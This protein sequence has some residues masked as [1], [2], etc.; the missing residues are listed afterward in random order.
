[1]QPSRCAKPLIVSAGGPSWVEARIYEERVLLF[2]ED[3]GAM[4][5]MACALPVDRC[6]G[7]RHHRILGALGHA[8]DRLERAVGVVPDA[9]RRPVAR[10][11]AGEA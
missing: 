8:G 9:R 1:M 11:N 7:P 6:D 4:R 5:S 10:R 3:R 2:A